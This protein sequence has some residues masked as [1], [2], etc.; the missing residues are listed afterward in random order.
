MLYYNE[1]AD[2]DT[3]KQQSSETLIVEERGYDKDVSLFLY[4]L[5]IY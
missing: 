4:T 1:V 2:T 5:H 3:C